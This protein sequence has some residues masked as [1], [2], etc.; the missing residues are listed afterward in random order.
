MRPRLST[1]LLA[2]L[3]ASALAAGASAQ[4]RPLVI[5]ALKGP[6]GIGLVKLFEKP[7][8][9]PDAGTVSP[10]AVGSADLMAAKVI[11]GE[12]DM[13]VLPVNMAAKLYSSGIGIRLVAVIGNGMVSFLTSDPSINSLADLRGKEIAVA[14]QGATPDYLFRR[15]L[16]GAG[17]DPDRDLRLSYALPYPEAAMALAAGKIS[18]AVLPE[19]FASLALA[20][21]PDLRPALD[22]GRLWTQATGEASYPMTALVASSTLAAQRPDAVGALLAACSSSIDWVKA[23]PKDAGALVEKLD[24]GLKAG[25]AEKAIPRSNYTYLSALQARAGIEA[26]LATFLEMAP[27]S[28]GGKLPDAAFYASFK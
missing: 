28:I 3:A 25:I 22:L 8:V 12:Y 27:A 17:L 2:L 18:C 23:N 5:A 26:L 6:S 11:S 1:A 19:P 15:L 16:K 24:L 14:G 7:P 9:L 20:S 4:S 10:I 13:A 21:K